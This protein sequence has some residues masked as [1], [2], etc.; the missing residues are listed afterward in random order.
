MF[1]L[2]LYFISYQFCTQFQFLGFN[3]QYDAPIFQIEDG[4]QPPVEL[5]SKDRNII[6]A[7]FTTFLLKNI[8]KIIHVIFC[9]NTNEPLQLK[10]KFEHFKKEVH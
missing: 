9:G 10:Y 5:A 6:A 8:G 3:N 1:F 7:T 2:K 4:C